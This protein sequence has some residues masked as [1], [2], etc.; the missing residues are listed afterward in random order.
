MFHEAYMKTS[1]TGLI[2]PPLLSV[3]YFTTSL[4]LFMSGFIHLDFA[5]RGI[6]NFDLSVILEAW[7]VLLLLFSALLMLV[8]SILFFLI[9]SL[10]LRI[11]FYS[12][13]IAWVYYML[14]FCVNI[15]LSSILVFLSPR[16]LALFLPAVIFLFFTT[17]TSKRAFSIKSG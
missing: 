14:A 4:T 17:L 7:P 6:E 3:L 16:T 10:A 11:V 5:S 9:P 13:L 8:S 12:S 2:Y 15:L 1:Q